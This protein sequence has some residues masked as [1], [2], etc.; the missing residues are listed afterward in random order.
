MSKTII[1]EDLTITGDLSGSATTVDIAGKVTGD[2]NAK[3]VDILVGG[4]VQG[5]VKATSAQVRG[6]L[7]GTLRL[8]TS[9]CTPTPASRQ[10]S[11]PSSSSRTR[12]HG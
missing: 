2:I 11:P 9:N 10:T 7:S 5:N 1:A 4:T 8:T 6:T 12:A 3:A